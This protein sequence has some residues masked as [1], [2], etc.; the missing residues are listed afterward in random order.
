MLMLESEQASGMFHLNHCNLLCHVTEGLFN[1]NSLDTVR[2]QS[3][4]C[5]SN[6]R[7]HL[8]LYFI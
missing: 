6:K 5:S 4:G 7:K 1:L 2:Y 8:R 3:D